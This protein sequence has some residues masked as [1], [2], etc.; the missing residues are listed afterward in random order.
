MKILSA[1]GFG[2]GLIILKIIMPEVFSGLEEALVKFFSVLTDV[3]GKFPSASDQS[4]M[5]Y[6]HA[7]PI[8]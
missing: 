1:I 6:P 3:M 7:V 5:I 4:A 8:P 2:I